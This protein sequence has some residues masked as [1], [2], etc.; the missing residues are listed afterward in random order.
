MKFKIGW[1]YPEAKPAR[2]RDIQ[3]ARLFGS[4]AV[5]VDKNSGVSIRGYWFQSHLYVTEIRKTTLRDREP[6]NRTITTGDESEPIGM[7]PQHAA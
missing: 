6:I 3:V 7:P 1:V 4:E 5:G 2:W